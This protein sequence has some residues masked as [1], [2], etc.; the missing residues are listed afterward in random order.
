MTDPFNNCFSGHYT[1]SDFEFFAYSVRMTGS[2]DNGSSKFLYFFLNKRM[3]LAVGTEEN[4]ELS[5]CSE[6]IT[7]ILWGQLHFSL[8]R[9]CLIHCLHI[10]NNQMYSLRPNKVGNRS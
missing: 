5:K 10:W 7:K 6:I 1:F 8:N 3:C 9:H 4:V 2:F